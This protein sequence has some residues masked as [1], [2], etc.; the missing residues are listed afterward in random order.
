MILLRKWYPCTL[1]CANKGL[2]IDDVRV[3]RDTVA[4]E[5]RP[6]ADFETGDFVQSKVGGATVERLE[7]RTK[8]VSPPRNGGGGG[9]RASNADQQQKKAVKKTTPLRSFGLNHRRMPRYRGI[10][11]T[12]WLFF[13]PNDEA[14]QPKTVGKHAPLSFCTVLVMCT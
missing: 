5:I 4:Q 12:F 3:L 6:G 9:N 11:S 14:P 2:T 8:A 10:N 13:F 1:L 7:S